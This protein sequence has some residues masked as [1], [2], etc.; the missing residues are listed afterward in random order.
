MAEER[1]NRVGRIEIR[2]GLPSSFPQKHHDRLMAVVER[3]TVHNSM[4]RM[5]EV[6]NHG[7][8]RDRGRVTRSQ[9]RYDP[10]P[11]PVQSVYPLLRRRLISA[12]PSRR[13]A[14]SGYR[15]A[16]RD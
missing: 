7:R 1:P 8:Y 15:A 6:H 14:R 16:A 3:C 13:C 4:V 11:L 2:L 5:P 10:V 12:G 9:L